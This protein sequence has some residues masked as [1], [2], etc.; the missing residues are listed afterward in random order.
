MTMQRLSSA[1]FQ[2]AKAFIYTHAR[3]LDTKLYEYHFEGG[4]ADAVLNA[5]AAF[6]N[7]DGGFGHG[8]E[9]D[10]R[11][12][13]SSPMATTVGLQYATAVS[14]LSTHPLVQNAIRYLINTYE[15]QN[16]YWPAA[17]ENVNDAPHAFW[18]HVEALTPP[19]EAAWPNPSAEITGYLHQHA[20]L[21]PADFL[22]AVTARAQQNLTSSEIISGD[23][24]QKYNVLCWQRALPYLPEGMKTAVTAAITRTYQTYDAIQPDTFGELSVLAFAPNPLSLLAQLAPETVA[25]CLDDE[26]NKQAE[27][28]GWWPSWH[29]GQYEEVWPVAKKEWAGII[30][31]ENLQVFQAFGRIAAD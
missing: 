2:K 11:L 18:W 27:D 9:P 31:V 30:T 3:P 12:A 23:T 26:L 21:V 24:P 1:R 20:S 22:T 29:W 7:A 17:F 8:L 16:A 13:A 4:S 19:V 14:A 15:T 10:F 5:L 28:G 25:Q 6:Q